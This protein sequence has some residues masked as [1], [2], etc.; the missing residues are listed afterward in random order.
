M[1]PCNQLPPTLWQ[2]DVLHLS[3]HVHDVFEAK[4][5]GLGLFE[6]ALAY[7]GKGPGGYGGGLR[8]KKRTSIII[9]DI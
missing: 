7:D 3:G 8:K 4:L 5:K 2:D 6:A 9:R 1:V